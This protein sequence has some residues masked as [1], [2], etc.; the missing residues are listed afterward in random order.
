MKLF[1]AQGL[2][3][4]EM[5]H[6][7]DDNDPVEVSYFVGVHSTLE[8]AKAQLARVANEERAN[9][10]DLIDENE[11]GEAHMPELSLEFAEKL[12]GD[13]HPRPGET[14]WVS[15]AVEFANRGMVC[16][17]QVTLAELDPED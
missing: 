4:D 15:D 16:K 11:T 7:T 8:G 3:Q 2:V 6:W 1:I 9:E 10:N 5:L 13:F 12:T 17:Y 14:Y